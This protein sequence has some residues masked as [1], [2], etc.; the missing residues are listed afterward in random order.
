MHITR[1][2]T[3]DPPLFFVHGLACDGTDWRAQ[4]R[5]LKPTMTVVTCDLPGHGLSPGTPAE[6]TIE[7]YGTAVA[8]ALAALDVPP[9]V[10]VGHS[11]G[12]RVVLAA[13]RR[14]PQA[15]AG[16]VL[17]DGSRIGAGDS[18]AAGQSMAD[19]LVGDGYL[20]FMRS[21]FESM[22]VPS[23][24]P[25]IRQ[26]I[27][28]RALRFP[29]ALGRP[30]LTDLAR[31][32]AGDVE[33]ALDAVDVPLLAIQSTTMDTARERVSLAPGVAS[34]W[35]DLVGSH[36]PRSRQAILP[37]SS[38][39]PQIELADEVTALIGDFAVAVKNDD[40]PR[41]GLTPA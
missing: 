21:F 25:A 35:L 7:A 3:G 20:R 34:P 5:T 26:A 6:C 11:M 1:V 24:D 23:S 36:V 18:E 14:R 17:V 16:L 32:D 37:G 29:A 40:H 4:V 41:E 27:V 10:L 33:G 9:A 12:C 13:S 39:F 31:W 28:D 15:V 2:G 19:E 8:Q 22:F 38:H 30:L